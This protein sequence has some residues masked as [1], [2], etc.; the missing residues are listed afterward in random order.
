MSAIIVLLI[1][2]LGLFA[3]A[4]LSKRRFGLLGLGLAAGAIISPIWG[5]NAGFVVSSTGL[6]PEGPIIN[7]IAVSAVILIPAILFMFHGYTY[8]GMFGRIVGSLLFTGLAIAFL[9]TPIES[10][11]ILSGPIGTVYGWFVSNREM[12]ISAGVVIAV[13]DVLIAKPVHKSEKKHH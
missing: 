9:V 10:A 12:V 2:I 6:V 7:A 4:F 13:I 11:L 5:E 3:G 8:K 1:I